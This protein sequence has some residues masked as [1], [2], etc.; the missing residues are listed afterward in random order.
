LKNNFVLMVGNLPFGAL[1]LDILADS[2]GYGTTVA[3]EKEVSTRQGNFTTVVTWG[4]NFGKLKPRISLGFR[5]PESNYAS[6]EGYTG[7]DAMLG[8]K[9]GIGGCT[10]DDTASVNGDLIIQRAFGSTGKQGDVD[11]GKSGNR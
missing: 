6:K 2:T 10:L 7:Y 8:I 9:A 4:N 3:G 11:T 5:W 1:R